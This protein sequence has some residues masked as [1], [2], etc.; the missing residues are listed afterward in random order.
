MAAEQPAQATTTVQVRNCGANHD[1]TIAGEADPAAPWLSWKSGVDV[2]A[3]GAE[4]TLSLTGDSTQVQPGTLDTNL[5]VLGG[6]GISTVHVTF[7]VTAPPP[8]PGDDGGGAAGGAPP[9][10]GTGQHGSSDDGGCGCRTGR[11]PT[12]G[13][14][15]MLG[16]WLGLMTLARRSRRREPEPRGLDVRSYGVGAPAAAS[17]ART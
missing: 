5:R 13:A 1:I 17:P 16:L 12:T 11:R 7:N 6:S 8:P 2:L 4:T 14:A 9:G 10:P 15:S 3:P